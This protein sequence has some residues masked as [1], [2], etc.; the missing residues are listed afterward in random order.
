[1]KVVGYQTSSFDTRDGNHISG[2]FLFVS[3][4]RKNVIGVATERLFLSD[5]KLNGYKPTLGD[6]I[7]PYYN[8]YGKVDF[9]ELL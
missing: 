2:C 6:E 8:K 4:E 9:I 3:E 1:M 7:K 5:N